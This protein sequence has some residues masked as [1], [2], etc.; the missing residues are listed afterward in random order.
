MKSWLSN[1]SFWADAFPTNEDKAEFKKIACILDISGKHPDRAIHP[2][3]P[4]RI[5]IL[6]GLNGLEAGG[7]VEILELAKKCWCSSVDEIAGKE[8]YGK[9]GWDLVRTSSAM[10]R[11]ALECI[12]GDPRR[13]IRENDIPSLEIVP[14]TRGHRVM[15]YTDGIAS[16]AF[17]M[18]LWEKALKASKEEFS[19]K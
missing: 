2:I 4:E 6:F 13:F 7:M 8:Y 9:D 3:S 5:G 12:A 18:K 16:G 11:I 17:R 19:R 15:I 1:L 10:S 14:W